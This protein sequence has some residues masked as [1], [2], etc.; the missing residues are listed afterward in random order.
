MTTPIG[1]APAAELPGLVLLLFGIAIEELGCCEGEVALV[2][3]DGIAGP[4]EAEGEEVATPG[5][6]YVGTENAN[7][8]ASDAT[9]GAVGGEGET[10]DPAGGD[11][12]AGGAERA[13]D[14]DGDGA[15]EGEEVEDD[16]DE[17]RKYDVVRFVARSI[18]LPNW[19]KLREEVSFDLPF[20]LVDE[21]WLL[22]VAE[23]GVGC[24]CCGSSVDDM[25]EAVEGGVGSASRLE[26]DE[27]DRLDDSPRNSILRSTETLTRARL[28][29]GWVVKTRKEM[30]MASSGPRGC[31]GADREYEHDGSLAEDTWNVED[32]APEVEGASCRTKCRSKAL[33]WRVPWPTSGTWLMTVNSNRK[34]PRGKGEGKFWIRLEVHAGYP[35]RVSVA[36]L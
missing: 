29:A 13:E 2:V 9:C 31:E 7:G 18:E 11:V 17:K 3:G 12:V 8:A 10:G 25:E 36:K 6:E 26:E 16:D 28:A 22:A 15:A 24:C 5:R 34:K 33:T 27:D 4:H 19:S 32:E 30:G 23:S 35:K 1:A 20:D 14:D 21:G